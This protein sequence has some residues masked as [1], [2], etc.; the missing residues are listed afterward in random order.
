MPALLVW[1]S[2]LASLAQVQEALAVRPA[3]LPQLKYLH[4]TQ[5]KLHVLC[6]QQH[7]VTG[8]A[9]NK[10]TKHSR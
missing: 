9:G 5:N 4:Y 8:T 2:H 1:L 10:L 6:S 7:V 3:F